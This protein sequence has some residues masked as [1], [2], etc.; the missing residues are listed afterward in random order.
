M[1]YDDKSLEETGIKEN[2]FLVVTV[3]IKKKP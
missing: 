1:T 3:M 2:D